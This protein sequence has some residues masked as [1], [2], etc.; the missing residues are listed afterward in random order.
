MSAGDIKLFP[1]ELKVFV[2]NKEVSLTPI[3]FE[4]VYCLLQHTDQPVKLN[5]ILQ[6]VW[7][8]DN[9]EN[10]DMLRVHF[11]HLRQKMEDNPKRWIDIAQSV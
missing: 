7:G 1:E 4:I 3:E 10:P 9:D 2:K 6:E 11:R 8:Y 5:Q